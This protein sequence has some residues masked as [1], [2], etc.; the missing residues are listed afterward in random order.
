MLGPTV[1]EDNNMDDVTG[2]EAFIHFLAIGWNVFFSIIPP[3]RYAGGWLAFFVA[4][5][6]IGGCTA[7]VAEFANLL[8]CAIKLR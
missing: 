2:K 5:T 4:L 6:A 1:D 7:I 8:G 3:R